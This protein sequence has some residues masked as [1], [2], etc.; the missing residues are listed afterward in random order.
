MKVLKPVKP[1][2]NPPSVRRARVMVDAFAGLGAV[3][4]G[5]GA[6]IESVEYR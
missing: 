4:R 5:A 1:V 6:E 2:L 3:R